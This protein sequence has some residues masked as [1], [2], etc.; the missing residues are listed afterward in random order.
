MQVCLGRHCESRDWSTRGRAP[1]RA[2]TVVMWDR[3]RYLM[4]GMS[5]IVLNDIGIGET[6]SEDV[7]DWRMEGW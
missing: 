6:T 3:L 7:T 1:N 5:H 2:A 4:E